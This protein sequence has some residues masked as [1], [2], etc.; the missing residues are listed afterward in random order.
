MPYEAFIS[1]YPVENE[2]VDDLLSSHFNWCE[3]NK[4]L[5]TPTILFNERELPKQYSIE[6]IKYLII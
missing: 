5:Y 4:I 3:K 2:D 6:D 1:K